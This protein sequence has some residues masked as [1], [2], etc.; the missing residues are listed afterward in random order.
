MPTLHAAVSP[1]V[2]RDSSA[3][4]RTI[5]SHQA[6]RTQ[7]HLR[8]AGLTVRGRGRLIPKAEK[9]PKSFGNFIAAVMPDRAQLLVRAECCVRGRARQAH[10][11][12]SGGPR[13]R[14]EAHAAHR[15]IRGAIVWSAP[16]RAA[17]GHD[18]GISSLPRREAWDEQATASAKPTSLRLQFGKSIMLSLIAVLFSLFSIASLHSRRSAAM[19][20]MRTARCSSLNGSD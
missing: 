12:P 7:V 13:R 8:A 19:T 11:E 16:V 3:A 4:G 1:I 9:P 14:R 15:G 20:C 18:A 5:P 6:W 17:L 10:P 2:N